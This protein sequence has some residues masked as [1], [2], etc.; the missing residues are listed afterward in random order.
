MGACLIYYHTKTERNQHTQSDGRFIRQ[1]CDAIN[2]R[3]YKVGDHR[4]RHRI[5]SCMV[6]NQP[7][8]GYFAFKIGL[9]WDLFFIPVVILALFP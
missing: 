2:Q 1:H 9:G 4:Q 7:L 3:I 6:W 8:A 5:A